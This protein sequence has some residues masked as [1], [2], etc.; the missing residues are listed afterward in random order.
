MLCVDPISSCHLLREQTSRLKNMTISRPLFVSAVW[1]TSG[2]AKA[3][4]PMLRSS[5]S[6]CRVHSTFIRQK[7]YSPPCKPQRLRDHSSVEAGTQFR[8]CRVH[9]GCNASCWHNIREKCPGC[10]ISAH[11]YI[12]ASSWLTSEHQFD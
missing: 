10:Q 2:P 9:K 3:L 5:A 6:G 4:A 12:V 8:R 11:L 1:L 7:T